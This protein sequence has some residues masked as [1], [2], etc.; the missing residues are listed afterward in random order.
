MISA[1][2]RARRTGPSRPKNSAVTY[3]TACFS[4]S[5][6]ERSRG[7]QVGEDAAPQGDHYQV[8]SVRDCFEPR[9]G[10]LA[11]P[12]AAVGRTERLV[13][14]STP[15]SSRYEIDVDLVEQFTISSYTRYL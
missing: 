14:D 11:L 4:A 2:H 7:R 1:S 12:T 15:P 8:A 5:S 3:L 6:A 13:P 9:V 10:Q